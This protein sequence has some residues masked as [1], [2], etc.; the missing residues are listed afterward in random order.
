MFPVL[1]LTFFALVT[2]AL[3][4][5]TILVG[6]CER[7]GKVAYRINRLWTWMILRAGGIALKVTG[8]EN[9]DRNKQYIFMVNHQS[10]MDIP[11]LVQALA[12]FQLRWIA[13]K[14]L[15][16]VPFLGWAMWAAKHI[17]VD[18][19]DPQ[20]AMKSLERA[21]R[22][23]AAGIS[24]VVYPEGTRSKDGKLLRFKKGGFLLAVQSK[25]AIVPV[26]INGSGSAL[27]AGAWLPKPGAIEVTVEQPIAIDGYRPGNLRVISELVRA[28]I[29]AHLRPPSQTRETDG[30]GE[31]SLVN[32]TA[33]KQHV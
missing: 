5:L 31:P 10:N 4:M 6:S 23:I 27:P 7:H 8:L 20:D 29:A 1:Q 24:V 15:L 19:A 17:T 32:Q 30:D 21:K 13:K 11:V 18:R 25:T 12:Q 2:I 3:S 22:H 26:T 9:L 28:K 33:D 14:E 16:R